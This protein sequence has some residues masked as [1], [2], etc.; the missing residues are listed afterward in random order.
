[1]L[2]LAAA[3]TGRDTGGRWFLG[4]AA[5]A[6]VGFWRETQT[7]RLDKPATM[8]PALDGGE[9][10]RCDEGAGAAGAA[11]G[12]PGGGSPCSGSVRQS[13]TV[14]SLRDGSMG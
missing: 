8:I 2:R 1:M 3:G 13:V 6:V 14:A 5:V 12:G 9:A 10:I 4:D 11:C 7:L